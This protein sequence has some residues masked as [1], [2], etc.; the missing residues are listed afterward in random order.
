[1]AINQ[2]SI[3]GNYIRISTDAID[4]T[5]NNSSDQMIISTFESLSVQVVHTG[6]A[7]TTATWEIQTSNDG[8][9]SWD[10]ITGSSTTTSG[11]SGSETLA[12]TDIPFERIRVTITSASAATAPTLTPY[13]V[14][15]KGA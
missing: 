1:M 15:K 3:G 8:G 9:T 5:G 12:L 11:A 2:E 4:A 7:A 14:A 13:V 6:F 10:T